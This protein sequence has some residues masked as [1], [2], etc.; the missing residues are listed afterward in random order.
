MYKI[1]LIFTIAMNF[2][3]EIKSQAVVNIPLSATDGTLTYSLSVGLDLSATNCIDPQLGELDNEWGPPTNIFTITFDLVPYGCLSGT[4]SFKDYRA[5]GNPPAFPFNGTI[6][7]TLEWHTSSPGL[8]INITYNIPPSATMY[9]TDQIGGVFLEIG[10]FTGQGVAT[11]PGSYTSIFTKAFLNMEYDNIIPV[12]LTSFTAS[13]LQNE[14]AI[15]LNWITVTET[16][17]SGFEIL[18]FT[19]NDNEWETISFVPGFGTTTEPKNYQYEDDYS[20]LAYEGTILYRL[21]QVDYDGSYEFSE[22]VAVDVTFV[23][24]EIYISQNYPNP[25]N[26]STTIIYS[27]PEEST[28]RIKI[29]NSVGELIQLLVS[30]TKQPGNYETVWNAENN[31]SGVY[32]YSFEIESING[33]K[34]NR[35][36]KKIVYMK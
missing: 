14:K 27:L 2:I 9:I 16:N 13:V 35:E 20:F 17:N 24:S 6:N 4:D 15:Q 3:T 23:P 22:Q 11:I 25:F 28:V 1:V 19:Q 34:S 30:E 18:R 33:N 7:H 10:P 32:F 8:P 21:K 29:Y 31:S 26:P 5:P 36:M 12:E